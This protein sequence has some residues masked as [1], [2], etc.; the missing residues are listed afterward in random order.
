MQWLLG[1]VFAL[2]V[3]L[4]ASVWLWPERPTRSER[5][6]SA[7]NARIRDRLAQAGLGHVPV[8][9]VVLVSVLLGLVAGAVALLATGVVALAPVA[10]LTGVALP[11]IGIGWRARTQRRARSMVWPDVIDHLVA[12]VRSGLAIPE[13]IC[14]IAANCPQSVRREFAA[15]ASD[16][17]AT[18]SFSYSLDRLKD[19][20]ADPVADRLL[21]TLRMGKEVG[22]TEIGAVLRQLGSYLRAEQATRGELLARQSW[23]VYAARLGL[24]APW[25]VLVALSFRPEAA[26]AYNTSG[27]LVVILFGAIVTFVAYRCMLAIGRLREESRFFA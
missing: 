18:G 25:L 14:G 19:S 17:R 3:L 13:A 6:P 8:F 4:I 2:G 24:V 9:A 22:G 16:Y 12:G 27:G 10:F 21:E 23:I 7:T 26:T 5:E 11:V 15:F 1:T 20:L